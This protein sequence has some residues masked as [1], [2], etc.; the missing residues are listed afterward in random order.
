MEKLHELLIKE[1]DK[2]SDLVRKMRMKESKNQ[3]ELTK[4][5]L[6]YE[7][8]EDVLRQKFFTER[9]LILQQSAQVIKNY[10]LK[11]NNMQFHQE[12]LRK[13]RKQLD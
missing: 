12:E 5:K 2:N 9:S 6:I 7:N 10:E 1:I 8:A 13:L 11:A 4:M 3:E